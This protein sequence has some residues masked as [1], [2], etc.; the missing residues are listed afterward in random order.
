MSKLV[1]NV[2]GVADPANGDNIERELEDIKLVV[3]LKD[4]SNFMFNLDFLL[5]NS[6]IEL[7][8]KWT[9]D[10]VL[11]ETATR[12]FKAAEDGPPALD[13]TPT[14]NRP[15][16]LKF[17]V[18]DCKLYLPVVTLL[19][20]YQNYLYKDLKTG[21]SIDFKWNKYRS[22]MINQTATNNLNFLIDPTFN[23]VNRLFV[24]A[25]ANKEDRR[26]FSK[27]YT[28]TVEIKDYNV[29]IDGER[30]YEIPIKNKEGTYKEIIERIRNHLLR[31]GNEFNFGYFCK[32]YKLIAIDLSKQKSD[33]KTQQINFI[34]KLAQK[35]TTF[36]IAE[37]KET[38]G[39]KVLQNSL[40]ILQKMES[41]KIIKLLQH[42][43]ENDRRFGTSK[44]FIVNEH[45]NGNYSQGDDVRSI[46]KFDTEI[47]RPFL[48]DYSN[49]YILVTANIKVQNGHDTIRVAIKN[50]HPFTRASFKL[51]TQQVDT[52]DNLDL[53]MNLYN[54]LEYSDNYADTAE[55]LYEYKRP[56]PRDNN[57]YVVNLATIFFQIS[58]RISS[59][60]IN[61]T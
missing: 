59:K 32:H 35:A 16:D 37:E 27:Y 55:S 47:V 39:L 24:L 23:N 50:C 17:I 34:G 36:F 43:D 3:P 57:G 53:T 52:A 15:K 45:N 21:I 33:L 30:F 19:T 5:I 40:T 8:L 2:P 56:E 22:Q 51:N 42:K 25:F 1:G 26:S 41:E 29:I 12:K 10:C 20:E 38:T 46:V 60:P 61:N 13:E 48:C 6:E 28:P 7:F 14:I 11:T 18:I 54:M 49:A 58:V 9:E 4:I 44:W 31:T